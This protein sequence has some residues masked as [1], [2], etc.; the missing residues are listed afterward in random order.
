M[1]PA[2]QTRHG[3][4]RVAILAVATPIGTVGCSARQPAVRRNDVAIT[5]DVEARLASDTE[6]SRSAIAVDTKAGV[7][8]LTGMV[9]TDGARNSIEQIARDTPGVRSVDN[10]VRFGAP[11]PTTR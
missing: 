2:R 10:D 8:H 4:S 6:S 11:A 7:V 3:L 9:A 1:K 5:N